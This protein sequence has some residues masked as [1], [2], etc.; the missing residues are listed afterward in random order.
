MNALTKLVSA[1]LPRL[2]TGLQRLVDARAASSYGP[3]VDLEA[4]GGLRIPRPIGTPSEEQVLEAGRALDAY[5]ALQVPVQKAARDWLEVI[6]S[7]VSN[8]QGERV[9]NVRFSALTPHLA[10]Y[11]ASVFN[12]ASLRD[13]VATFGHWPSG[14]ELLALLD[15]HLDIIRETEAVLRRVANYRS[16]QPDAAYTPAT[17]EE[18]EAVRVSLA[19]WRGQQN[20]DR[21]EAEEAAKMGAPFPD[22]TLTRA[23]LNQ[24]AGIKPPAAPQ[25][26]DDSEAPEEA[27]QGEPA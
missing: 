12:D 17:E 24:A 3:S 11:P 13:A 8:P 5:V 1:H 9:F 18:R 23:Q 6:N 7:V 10:R 21:R 22:V 4:D 20:L 27:W 14:Q 19:K 26:R 15:R 16:P 2:S 25:Q